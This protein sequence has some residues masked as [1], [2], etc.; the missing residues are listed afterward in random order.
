MGWS[1]PAGWLWMAIWIVALLAMV[2]LIVHSAGNRP[3]GE[4]A[5][6]ILRAR[7]A[8]G[9]ISQDE[10]ER[11]RSTLLADLRGQR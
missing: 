4:D 1:D 6:A 9:E 11:A 8:R 5:L 10:Y 3:P 2:W 7:F